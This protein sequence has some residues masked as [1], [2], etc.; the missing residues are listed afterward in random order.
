[1]AVTDETRRIART[2]RGQIVD[3]SDATVVALVAAW[4]ETYD[5]L[6]PDLERIAA[7]IATQFSEGA[8]PAQLN[9]AERVAD[10]LRISRE[11]TDE[12]VQYA[13]NRIT[14]DIPSL[15]ADA[16]SSHQ[17]MLRSQ[18]PGGYASVGVQ[19]GAVSEDALAAMVA[20]TTSRIHSLTQPLSPEM[21]QGM[22]RALTR[23]I[24]GG[25]N[26]RETARR[27][28]GD[29]EGEFMGGISRASTIA[30]TESIGAMRAADALNAEANA[31]LIEANIWYAEL[32]SGRTC[33][34]CMSLHGTEHP[35][36]DGGPLGHPNCR[37]TYVT[38]LKGW[39]ELGIEGVAEP[40]DVISPDEGEKWFLGLTPES[41]EAMMGPG[42]YE[43][44]SQGQIG[45]ED[46]AIRRDNSDWRT[47]YYE[48]P[49]KAFAV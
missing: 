48:R 8:T 10:A 15:A 32:D 36:D 43:L 12:L 44:W 39:E 14:Q 26:P 42:R 45:F 25:I 37:C 21:E 31:D 7:D 33:L 9:Q 24:V 34:A 23:G 46:F 4:V 47:A 17:Q 11:R 2:R 18:L 6:A 5:D 27:I 35:I 41:Q 40:P 29:L 13:G 22:K 16:A 49:L 20:R 1:M 3:L 38:K 19:L 30:R 28:V